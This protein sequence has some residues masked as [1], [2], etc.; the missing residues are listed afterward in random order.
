MK[1]AGDKLERGEK[2]KHALLQVIWKCQNKPRNNEK[3]NATTWEN[4]QEEVIGFQLLEDIK[5]T[6]LGILILV[7]D[8][9]DKRKVFL[10]NSRKK[11]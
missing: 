5:L 1:V 3:I 9:N 8:L 6:I 7:R 10:K 11:F 2:V 4:I